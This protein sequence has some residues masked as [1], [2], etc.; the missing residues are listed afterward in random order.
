VL[1]Q[2]RPN[3]APIFRPATHHLDRQRVL[4]R[5]L[6][7]TPDAS[8]GSRVTG[9]LE[10]GG[11]EVRT[12][13][14]SAAAHAIIGTRPHVVMVD[15]QVQPEAMLS[16]CRD[17]RRAT[18]TPMIACSLTHEASQI[19]GALQAGA[20]DFFVLP[21]QTQEFVARV[22]AV[23]RRVRRASVAAPSADR[24][25]AGDVELWLREHRVYRNGR[26]IDLTPTEFRLLGVLARDSGRALTHKSLLKQAW[27]ADYTTSRAMLRIYIRRLR[28]K[29]ADDLNDPELIVAVRGVG[30][31]FEP[32][33]VVTPTAA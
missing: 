21:M 20:D 26:L 4:P 2:V 7:V 1:T 19:V 31:R 17:L 8:T 9:Y 28:A 12:L 13:A 14:S 18:A 16:F 5:A 23:V 32:A 25:V 30:Y 27:G 3:P 22:R 6:V 15:L 11:F 24:I 29:L 10:R 33:V